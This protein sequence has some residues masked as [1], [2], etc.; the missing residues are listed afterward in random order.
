MHPQHVLRDP[1]VMVRIHLV[2]NHKDH[3]K[4]GEEGVLHANVIHWRLVLVIL[5]KIGY[6]IIVIFEDLQLGGNI[7]YQNVREGDKQNC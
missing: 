3:V 5:K 1:P 6:I 2:K 7:K 4:S